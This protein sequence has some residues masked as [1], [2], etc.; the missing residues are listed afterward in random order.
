MKRKKK[1]KKKTTRAKRNVS[2]RMDFR[3]Q[4]ESIQ[5]HFRFNFLHG[6]FSYSLNSTQSFPSHKNKHFRTTTGHLEDFS[7]ISYLQNRFVNL[8]LKFIFL[9]LSLSF[10]LFDANLNMFWSLLSSSNTFFSSH[11]S[12][13]ERLQ[14]EVLLSLSSLLCLS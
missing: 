3:V 7:F 5:Q 6:N 8:K 11:D 4:L 9:D 2:K 13:I 1:S 12:S 14:A 10:S